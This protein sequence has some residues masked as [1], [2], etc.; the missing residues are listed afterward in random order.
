VSHLH[1]ARG[2]VLGERRRTLLRGAVV[3]PHQPPRLA[4]RERPQDERLDDAEHGHGRADAEAD[5]EDGERGQPGVAPQRA[6]GLPK[7]AEHGT[8]AGRRAKAAGSV[9]RDGRERPDR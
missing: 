3:D 2:E 5:D 9:G 6:E 7:V 1:R 8:G 4:E